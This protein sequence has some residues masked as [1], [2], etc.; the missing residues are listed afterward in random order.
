MTREQ[1][2]LSRAM[3]FVDDDLI[4]AAHA[5]RKKMR[6]YAPAL[7]AACLCVVI[8]ATFPMVRAFVG[9]MDKSND[10]LPPGDA[11]GPNNQVPAENWYIQNAPEMPNPSLG[12]TAPIGMTDLTLL[13]LT[14][15]TATFRMV[16]RDSQPLWVAI[17]QYAGGLLASTEPDFTDNGTILRPRQIR[18]SVDG[19]DQPA[20]TL[21][22]PEGTYTVKLDFSSLRNSDYRMEDTLIFYRYTDESG[23]V[24]HIRFN[25]ALPAES[26]TA[27]ASETEIETE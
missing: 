18:V 11:G 5:P 4:A 19:V 14:D 2:I 7:I 16:K 21:P 27:P 10:A 24:E 3:N 15:T 6:H 23:T 20:A 22:V 8:V 12:D 17:R 1:E 9:D 26:E 13:A 25:I